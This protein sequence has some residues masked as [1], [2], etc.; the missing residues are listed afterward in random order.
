MLTNI[1]IN[2]MNRLMEENEDARQIITQLLENHQSAVSTIA[3][4]IRNP[5]T[6]ISS[7]LQI[8]QKQHPEV[9]EFFNW[10][11]TMEDIDFM[12]SLLNELSTFNNGNTLHPSVFSIEKLL[13][14]VVISF[15]ISLDS[16]ESDIKFSSRIH[17]DMGNFTGDKTK[18]EQ[19]LLNLLKN[20][21]EAVS[22]SENASIFFSA[23]R[24]NNQLLIQCQDNGTGIPDEIIQTIFDPF[25]TYKENGT[26][27]GLAISRRIAEAHG[28]T[29]TAQSDAVNGTVFSLTLPV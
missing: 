8:M 19:V 12:C 24:I 26:G 27:L 29:L 11:Q 28:G 23:E 10:N 20:A 6:L 9:K 18:L 7:S 21:K 17:P 1:D 2:K 14:N 13:R 22:T 5:L 16:E 25:V 15:A 4:E 3:H